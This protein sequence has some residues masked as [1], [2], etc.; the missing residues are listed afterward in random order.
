M[1]DS[2]ILDSCVIAA[3][4]FPEEAS[5]RAAEL[6]EDKNVITVDLALAEIANVAW[7]RIN[8]FKNSTSPVEKALMKCFEFINTSCELKSTSELIEYAFKIAVRENL[9]VYDS[10]FIAASRREKLPLYTLDKKLKIDDSVY[11]L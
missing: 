4:F 6:V 10:L 8:L 2:C 9:T 5:N 1:P 11:L 3:V 7:K